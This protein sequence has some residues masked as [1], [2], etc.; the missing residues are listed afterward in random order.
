MSR[1]SLPAF[2]MGSATAKV[3]RAEDAWNGRNPVVVATAYTP[4]SR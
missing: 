4:T 1:P 3:R 2:D